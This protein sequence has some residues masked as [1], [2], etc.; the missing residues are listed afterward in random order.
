MDNVNNK[1]IELNSNTSSDKL[2]ELD[3]NT[4]LVF[5][6]ALK[7]KD[8]SIP[9]IRNQYKYFKAFFMTKNQ[10]KIFQPSIRDFDAKCLEWDEKQDIFKQL[11]KQKNERY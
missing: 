6:L 9:Q 8:F 2:V 7:E 1:L 11:K 5:I 3:N 10:K 4:I